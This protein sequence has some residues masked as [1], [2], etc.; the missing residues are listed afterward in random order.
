M[1]TERLVYTTEELKRISDSFE[2]KT[3]QEVLRWAIDEFSP[4]ISL[5]CSFG[6]ISG[7]VLL[8]MVMKINP[9]VEKKSSYQRV[10]KRNYSMS[11]Q[12]ISLLY[13]IIASRHQQSLGVD[14]SNLSKRE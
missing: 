5:S 2:G 13:L 14:L 4:D 7:M 6:G 12:I 3:P 8:D 9:K 11:Y 1:T 10:I